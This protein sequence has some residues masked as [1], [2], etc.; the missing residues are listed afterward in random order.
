MEASWETYPIMAA[1]Y[2]NGISWPELWYAQGRA[3]LN[4]GVSDADGCLYHGRQ[5]VRI[6]DI[7]QLS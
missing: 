3:C 7:S 1:L 6:W 4:Q 5:A 2:R